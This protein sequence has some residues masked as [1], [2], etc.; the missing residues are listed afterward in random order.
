MLILK[1]SIA[2]YIHI[3]EH[4][5]KVFFGKLKFYIQKLLIFQHFQDYYISSIYIVHIYSTIFVSFVKCTL[6]NL[7]CFF[8]AM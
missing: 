2:F 3:L 6:L 1:S 7:T 4:L 5:I 8:R